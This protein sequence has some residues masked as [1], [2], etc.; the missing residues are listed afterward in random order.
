M[1]F[2][3]YWFA[4]GIG[5]AVPFLIKYANYMLQ[6]TGVIVA[7][8]PMTSIVIKD[9]RWGVPVATARF[10]FGDPK[11]ATTTFISFTL[12]L[13]FGAWYIDGLP[14]PYMADM[15]LPQ[16]WVVALFLAAMMEVIA[17][18]IVRGIVSWTVDK[19]NKFR[20]VQIAQKPTTEE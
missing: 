3:F 17:P 8:V 20:G 9:Q 18:I 12:E 19:V 15:V 13:V 1:R 14:L 5:M 6:E 7:K 4:W 16:H 10:L 11:V 2:N